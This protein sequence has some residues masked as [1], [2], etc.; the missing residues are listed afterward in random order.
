MAG[1]PNIIIVLLAMIG[2]C[3]ALCCGYAIHSFAVGFTPDGNGFKPLSPEQ[4]DY[5]REMRGRNLEVLQEEGHRYMK[6]SRR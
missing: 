2:A 5:M 6:S 3:A 1:I 4:A